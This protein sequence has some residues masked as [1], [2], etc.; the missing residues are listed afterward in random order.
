[1]AKSKRTW[2]VSLILA[3]SMSG[4]L[5]CNLPA[6]LAAPRAT[7]T[8]QLTVQSPALTQPVN[9]GGDG[10]A[11]QPTI[12]VLPTGQERNQP[13]EQP[14]QAQP[15]FSEVTFCEDVT[16]D[17]EIIGASTEF[18]A[19]TETV[20]AYFTFENMQDGQEWGRLWHRDGEVYVDERQSTWD[21]GES[22]WVAY[23]ISDETPLK[24]DYSLTLYIGDQV[25]QEAS[26]HVAAP[27]A[28]PRSGFA[29]FGKITFAEG[30][31]DESVPIGASNEFREGITKIY[32]TFVYMNMASNQNWSREWLYNGEQLVRKE[33]TWD[34][35][36]EGM[37]WVSY[38]DEEGLK[39]G[40]YTL[41][42]YLDGQLARSADFLVVGE[43]TTLPT[44]QTR[45]TVQELID[46]DLMKAYQILANSKMEILKQLADLVE[47]AQIEIQMDDNMEGST[48]AV[49]RYGSDTCKIQEA[50]RRR[51]GRVLVNRQAWERQSWE[52]VAASIAHELIHAYQ[53]LHGGYRCEGCSIET[54]YEAFTVTIY[55]LEELGAWDIVQRKYGD[56]IDS[57]GTIYKSDLWKAIKATYTDCPDY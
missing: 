12:A 55:A 19:G 52:E 11:E 30:V 42:L 21:D 24:G 50:A 49:Y 16:D 1:M 38:S 41:N 22:G 40:T 10:P 34:E 14:T 25:V 7:A 2:I 53:H 17:G 36:V 33:L 51:P 37:S 28:Q 46:P 45:K 8:Q 31:T 57:S 43:K 56:Y 39:A 6:L 9:P 27:T 32:A 18:P 15:V 5:S 13:A 47:T 44:E 20:W 3:V 48:L 4:M 23:S 54:E 26:F 29:A 35:D